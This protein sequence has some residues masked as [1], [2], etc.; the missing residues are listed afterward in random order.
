MVT[1][2]FGDAQYKWDHRTQLEA[3]KRFNGPRPFELKTPPYLTAQPAITTTKIERGKQ[4]FL[5]MA[6]DGMWDTMSSSQAVDLVGEWLDWQAAGK[7]VQKPIM[8]PGEFG[9]FDLAPYHGVMWQVEEKKLA[10]QDDNVAVHLMRNALGGRHQ[11]MLHGSFVY[12][13]TYARRVRD[14]MTIQVV[15]FD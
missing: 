8:D 7:P 3:Q 9:T 6:T 1:R 11:D 5:I 2:A 4:T 15:F 13:P 10:L 14:D 12:K